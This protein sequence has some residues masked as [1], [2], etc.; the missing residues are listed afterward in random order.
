MPKLHDAA[1]RLSKYYHVKFRHVQ[2]VPAIDA[3]PFNN[4]VGISDDNTV[5]YEDGVDIGF[6][7][8]ELGHV[9]FGMQMCEV[10]F[11]AWEWQVALWLVRQGLEV[12][13]DWHRSMDD[14]DVFHGKYLS[15]R[16]MPPDVRQAYLEGHLANLSD[17]VRQRLPT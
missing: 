1:K 6:I 7:I 14:Y 9:L 4:H 5:L 3:A 15:Y 13:D 10:D 2:K 8:H 16:Q 17:E 11:L 12:E